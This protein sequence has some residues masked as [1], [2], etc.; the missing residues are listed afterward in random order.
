MTVPLSPSSVG[1]RPW[2]NG[3]VD[4]EVVRAAE[5][6]AHRA[7][8]RYAAGPAIGGAPQGSAARSLAQI[9]HLPTYP[10]DEPPHPAAGRGRRPYAGR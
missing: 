3:L 6:R 4:F 5:L 9:W 1:D 8:N 10:N 7:G 2:L